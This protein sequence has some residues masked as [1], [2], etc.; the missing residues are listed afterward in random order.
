MPRFGL[1]NESWKRLWLRLSKHFPSVDN[2][3]GAESPIP[4]REPDSNSDIS[5][6]STFSPT[7]ESRDPTP[8]PDDLWELLELNR[9]RH[10]WSEEEYQFERIF[11]KEAII[12]QDR[13]TRED[14]EGDRRRR[15]KLEIQK[16]SV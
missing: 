10:D 16:I 9:R 4:P 12:D 8:I 7:P 1:G 14:E 11:C 2:R 15:E 6:Y 5:G 13:R 3:S